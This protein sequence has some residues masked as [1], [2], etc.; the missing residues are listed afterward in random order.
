MKSN[1]V[2]PP[3]KEDEKELWFVPNPKA[4]GTFGNR[5]KALMWKLFGMSLFRWSPEVLSR[6]RCWLLRMFGARIGMNCYISNTVFV[7]QPW[8]LEMGDWVAVDEGCYLSTPI[9]LESRCGISK[10]CKLFSDGHDVRSRGFEWFTKP[11]RIGA[12]AFVGADTYISSGVQVGQFACIGSHSHVLK[13]VPENTIAYG[14]PC[15]VKSARIPQE[16]YLKYR[17]K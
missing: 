1:K 3:Y 5:K 13:N 11:I 16:E 4:I 10:C 12:G 6:Y 9:V 17:F 8:L 15:E 14:T 7:T 2:T